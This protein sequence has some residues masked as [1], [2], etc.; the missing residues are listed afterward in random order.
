[1][2]NPSLYV[3]ISL[4]RSLS[5]F[6]AFMCS[7]FTQESHGGQCLSS[8]SFRLSN[9]GGENGLFFSAGYPEQSQRNKRVFSK[10]GMSFGQ[11][12]TFYAKESTPQNAAGTKRSQMLEILDQSAPSLKMGTCTYFGTCSSCSVSCLSFC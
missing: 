6:I 2:V 10:K 5:K 8:T 12:R 1:M 9:L 7:K 11:G 3:T 4:T